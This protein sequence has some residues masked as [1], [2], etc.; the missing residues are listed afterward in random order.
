MRKFREL[1]LVE[2]FLVR[3]GGTRKISLDLLKGMHEL[4]LASA[5]RAKR[6]AAAGEK[7]GGKKQGKKPGRSR[8]DTALRELERA[9]P[10]PHAHCA[11]QAPW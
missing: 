1:D 5:Q 11:A 6:R 4:M 3:N 9:P 10:P 8:G 2:L 7:E